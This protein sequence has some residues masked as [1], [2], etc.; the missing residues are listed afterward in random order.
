V[1]F[2]AEFERG[3]QRRGI[4]LFVLPPRSPKL[5]GHV[6]RAQRTDTE[7]FYEV[8]ELEWTVP[9]VNHQLREWER[10]YHTVRPH[11]ALGHRTPRG[12]QRD[13]IRAG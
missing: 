3:C 11:H 4:R 1:F 9:A 2:F 13:L 6:E 5:D 12:F 8:T 10:I 7:E